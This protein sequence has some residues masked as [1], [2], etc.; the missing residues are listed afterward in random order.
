MN[1]AGPPSLK[2]FMPSTRKVEPSSSHMIETVLR[3]DSD[4]ALQLNNVQSVISLSMS[5]LLC[6]WASCSARESKYYRVASGFRFRDVIGG[7]PKRD[8]TP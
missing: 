5:L 6:D 1:V 3:V 8:G 2:L 7:A 4:H